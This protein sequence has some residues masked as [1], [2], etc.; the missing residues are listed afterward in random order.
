MAFNESTKNNLSFDYRKFSWR[1]D[2]SSVGDGDSCRKGIYP[3]KRKKKLFRATERSMTTAWGMTFPL[4]LPVSIE[5]L[6]DDKTLVERFWENFSRKIPI[7]LSTTPA[8]E[9]WDTWKITLTTP[10]LK[11]FPVFLEATNYQQHRYIGLLSHKTT[12]YLWLFVHVAKWKIL[13]G[14]IFLICSL[15]TWLFRLI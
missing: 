11:L 15:T 2:N 12:L 3:T 8:E 6:V 4:K 1:H 10:P 9:I 5:P 13:F 14:N 7:Y